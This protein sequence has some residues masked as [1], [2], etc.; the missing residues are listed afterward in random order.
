MFKKKTLQV[1]SSINWKCA[2]KLYTS[3]IQYSGKRVV[4]TVNYTGNF[5]VGLGL[6]AILHCSDS[7]RKQLHRESKN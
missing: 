5:S 7:R 6:K 2:K 4:I 3:T 1:C